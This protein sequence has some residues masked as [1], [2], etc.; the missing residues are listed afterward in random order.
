VAAGPDREVPRFQ[1][2][3]LSS[4]LPVCTPLARAYSTSKDVRPATRPPVSHASSWVLSL[5]VAVKLLVCPGLRSSTSAISLPFWWT[6]KVASPAP[7]LVAEKAI[8]TVLLG[9]GGVCL[10]HLTVLFGFARKVA[11]DREVGGLTEKFE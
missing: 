5:R 11:T 2:L 8:L 4:G 1:E 6:A 7:L 9:K 10:Y 3:S